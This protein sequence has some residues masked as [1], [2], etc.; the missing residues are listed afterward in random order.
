MNS[1][2]LS[3][4]CHCILLRFNESWRDQVLFLIGSLWLKSIIRL[5]QG[6]NQN[7]VFRGSVSLYTGIA[8]FTEEQLK[9]LNLARGVTAAVGMVLLLSIS[10]LLICHKAFSNTF[11]RFY[12]YLLIVTFLVEVL[13]CL[14]I[15]RQFQYK[16]QND[17]CVFLG[18]TT[19]LLS[20]TQM[21][22]T[23]KIIVYLFCLVI[24]SIQKNHF[25]VSKIIQRFTEALLTLLP[26]LLA[27]IFHGSVTLRVLGASKLLKFNHCRV[28]FIIEQQ[29]SIHCTQL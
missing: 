12:F 2:G 10:I 3:C 18:Y 16:G 20:V 5:P 23:F 9:S 15:E 4:K 27:F 28:A 1:E 22:Y 19:Q 7:L 29:T 14:S 13:I 21:F 11:Q 6:V 8:H 26:A 17:I 24:F 25:Q